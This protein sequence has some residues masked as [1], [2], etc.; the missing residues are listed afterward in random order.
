MLWRTFYPWRTLVRFCGNR[1]L[2][3]VGLVGLRI[4]KRFA[5]R[6][7]KERSRL[8]KPGTEKEEMGT[9]LA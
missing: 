8:K 5:L 2:K 6:R 4:E 3:V 7:G 9:R 1:L